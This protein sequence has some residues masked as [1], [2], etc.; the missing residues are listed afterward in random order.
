MKIQSPAPPP[1]SAACAQA[2]SVADLLQ[3]PA[4]LSSIDEA[5]SVLAI[6]LSNSA[7]YVVAVLAALQL[8]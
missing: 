7:A 4:L 3:E 1:P 2:G 5:S 8:G 6:F